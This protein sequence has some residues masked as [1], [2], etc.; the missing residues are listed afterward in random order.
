MKEGEDIAKYTE[1]IQKWVSVV[2]DVGGKIDDEI[3]VSKVLRTLLPINAISVSSIQEIRCTTDVTLDALVGRLTTFE[4]D[5]FDNY[6]PNPSTLKSAFKAKLNLVRRI[7]KGNK[8]IVTVV[9]MNLMMK[10][11]KSLKHYLQK[12]FPQVKVSRKEVYH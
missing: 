6:S 4:L 5:N 11:Q 9:M 7:E 1:R 10:T 12:E 8:L 2:S 3:V